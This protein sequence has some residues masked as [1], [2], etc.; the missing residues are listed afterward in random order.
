VTQK[1]LITDNLE[2]DLFSLMREESLGE[3]KIDLPAQQVIRLLGNPLKKSPIE[4]WGAD[5]WLEV[6]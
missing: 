1:L 5:H 6:K 4:Y 3:L 2:T